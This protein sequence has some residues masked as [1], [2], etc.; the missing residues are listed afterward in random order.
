MTIKQGLA[1][2]TKFSLHF[3]E[4][5]VELGIGDCQ[6]REFVSLNKF[7]NWLQNEMDVNAK[8]EVA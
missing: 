8:T 7:V 4:N 1:T 3:N 5:G 6:N 2:Y